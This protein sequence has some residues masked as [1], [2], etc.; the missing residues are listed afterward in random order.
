MRPTTSSS[1]GLRYHGSLDHVQG[2]PLDNL[3][4]CAACASLDCCAL[5]HAA[6]RMCTFTACPAF[7]R[8]PRLCQCC[9]CRIVHAH[10]AP[11]STALDLCTLPLK[12]D[13]AACAQRR[14][15]WPARDHADVEE[16]ARRVSECHEHWC[17]QAEFY[18]PWCGYCKVCRPHSSMQRVGETRS[19]PVR[20]SRSLA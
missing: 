3:R 2:C 1:A 12:I 19:A 15:R 13:N 11:C 7:Q 14:A 10:F 16:A 5:A 20:K 17:M 9:M 18:A 4:S 6:M 8:L